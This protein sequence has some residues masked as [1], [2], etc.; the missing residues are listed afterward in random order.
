MVVVGPE[1]VTRN[2]TVS[3]ALTPV[4]SSWNPRTVSEHPLAGTSLAV[5]PDDPSVVQF[6]LLVSG[7]PVRVVRR[8]V[9]SALLAKETGVIAFATVD[10][11]VMSTQPAPLRLYWNCWARFA[12]A[13][14]PAS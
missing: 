7:E 6:E 11:V 3:P 4:D 5:P 10:E 13:E 12:A 14:P 8:T 1:I 9:E 2:W